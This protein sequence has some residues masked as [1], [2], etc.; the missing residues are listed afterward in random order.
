[1]VHPAPLDRRRK[2]STSAA[3]RARNLCNATTNEH[4]TMATQE[5]GS[6]I[7]GT[8]E[9]SPI[10]RDMYMAEVGETGDMTGGASGETT[11]VTFMDVS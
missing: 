4:T 11:R 10:E 7:G 8:S 3:E 6:S 2:I 5:G 9:E 1:M